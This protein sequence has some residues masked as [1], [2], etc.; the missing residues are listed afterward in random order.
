MRILLWLVRMILR[1]I[2]GIAIGL[3]IWVIFGRSRTGRS[4]KMG[5]SLLR[6]LSRF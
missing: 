1:R 5:V 2:V 6:R 3:L 4:V